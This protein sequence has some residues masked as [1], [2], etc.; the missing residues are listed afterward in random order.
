MNHT[1]SF[2]PSHSKTS[3]PRKMAVSAREAARRGR[4]KQLECLTAFDEGKPVTFA[5]ST[6]THTTTPLTLLLTS[7]KTYSFTH[8][9]Y[10][11]RDRVAL[12]LRCLYGISCTLVHAQFGGNLVWEP[13]C[14]DLLHSIST[15]CLPFLKKMVHFREGRGERQ[16]YTWHVLAVS[17]MCSRAI[18]T[19]GI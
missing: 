8:L 1:L 11:I 10:I 12:R 17:I 18:C 19:R 3:P 2:V 5:V 6:R 4:V 13:Y 14:C 16:R 9:F 7:P 15:L